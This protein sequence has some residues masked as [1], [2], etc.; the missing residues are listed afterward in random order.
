MYII[1]KHLLSTLVKEKSVLIC[2]SKNAKTKINPSVLP[3]TVW[4]EVVVLLHCLESS[5]NPE[6]APMELFYLF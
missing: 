2:L 1:K 5:D 6:M 3:P 4:A